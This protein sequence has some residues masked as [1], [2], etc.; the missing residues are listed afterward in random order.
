VDGLLE[1]TAAAENVSDLHG[2]FHTAEMRS[3]VAIFYAHILR[4]CSVAIAWYQSK[5]S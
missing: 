5:T 3:Y 2:L 4:F 1:I